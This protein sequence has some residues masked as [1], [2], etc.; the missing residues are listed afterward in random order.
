VTRDQFLTRYP[1]FDNPDGDELAQ[2]CLAEAAAEIDAVVYGSRFDEAHG[3]LAAHKLWT[4]AF[5]VSLRQEGSGDEG[6]SKY[7]EAFKHVQKAVTVPL[8]MM[9]I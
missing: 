2:A 3:S 8:S 4:S 1:E 6:S 5:G 9:V 7:L